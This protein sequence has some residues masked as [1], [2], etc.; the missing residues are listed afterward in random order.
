MC[1]FLVHG[2]ILH[3]CN[4]VHFVKFTSKLGDDVI[5]RLL[6]KPIATFLIEGVGNAGVSNNSPDSG[7]I[8][9]KRTAYHISSQ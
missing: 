3:H 1:V 4:N 8:R 5:S 9:W 7:Q 2:I 6:G